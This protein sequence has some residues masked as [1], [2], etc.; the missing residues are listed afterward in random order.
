MDQQLIT[1]LIN[2]VST[3][4]SFT[5]IYFDDEDGYQETIQIKANNLQ[6]AKDEILRIINNDM[7][8]NLFTW[9][10]LN[11][12]FTCYLFNNQGNLIA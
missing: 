9:E 2:K 1:N 7:D 8:N 6:E 12:S 4:T 5:F 10:S 3:P 11:N